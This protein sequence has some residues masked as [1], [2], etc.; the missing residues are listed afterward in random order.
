MLHVKHVVQFQ[1]IIHTPPKEGIR[2]YG[3]GEMKEERNV[4]MNRSLTGLSRGVEVLKKT[5]PRG[6]MDIFTNYKLVQLFRVFS[7][8]SVYQMKEVGRLPF[9]YFKSIK[10]RI[11]GVSMH[12][13]ASF[14]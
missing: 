1:T 3:V 2:I 5:L 13:E 7:L 10:I 11:F 4:F 12:D 9:V 6:S 8:V 14:V